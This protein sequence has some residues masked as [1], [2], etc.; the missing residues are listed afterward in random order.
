MP[1]PTASDV[2]A[3]AEAVDGTRDVDLQVVTDASGALAWRT[4]LEPGDT[5]LFTVRT[6]NRQSRPAAVV[7]VYANGMVAPLA[8]CDA[9]FWTEA[10]VEKFVWPYYEGHG[11]DVKG[12]RQ[13]YESDPGIVGVAHDW[14]TKPLFIVAGEG[15]LQLLTWDQY[16]AR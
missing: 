1:T 5:F 2:R 7:T 9:A 8:G 14:P 15:G 4:V 16:S 12:F 11:V 10:A 6:S 13:A 3:L